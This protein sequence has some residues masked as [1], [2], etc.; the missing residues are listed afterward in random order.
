MPPTLFV[1]ANPGPMTLAG[2]NTW[3]LDGVEPTLIDAG[4]GDPA[5]VDGLA[6]HLRD[7]PLARVLITHAH[8]D[9]ASGIGAL[10]QRWPGLDACKWPL[11]GEPGCWRPLG[12]GDWIAAGDRRLQVVHT[13]GHALDHVC[14]WDRDAR[15]LFAGDMVIR[16]TTVMIPTRG[17]NLRAYLRSLD[18]L[19]AL[20]PA[21]ILPGHG[22]IIDNPIEAIQIYQRHRREREEQVRACLVDGVTDVDQIV[23]RLYRGLPA[24]LS[25][26]ARQTIQAHID[27]LEE[28]ATASG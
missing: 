25:A 15:D 23:G 6:A 19:A 28:D 3:L 10:R 12:D 4:I 27:K 17:G 21:R 18:R 13:P 22:V 5:Q 7:R 14:F 1:S 20:E 26:A 8:G 2:T 9:H 16:G 24:A 11:P